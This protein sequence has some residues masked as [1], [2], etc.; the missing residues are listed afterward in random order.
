MGRL[1]DSMEDLANGSPACGN[2]ATADL[3]LHADLGIPPS[4]LAA[5]QVRRVTDFE[6]REVLAVN[7]KAG[8]LA[9]LEYP[10]IDP[11]TGQRVTS[12]VRR[13]HPPVK[14]DGSPEAKY[15]SGYGDNRHLYFPPHC[16]P[17][18]TDVAIPVV[19]VEAEKSV[20]AITAAAER[21]A[22]PV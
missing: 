1:V 17:M 4:L 18:L 11:D 19:I 20:L 13:D 2:L 21:T 14:P 7:G 5:A 9:G 6:A 15:M 12:R 3:K 10:Y 16:A 22:R 8:N